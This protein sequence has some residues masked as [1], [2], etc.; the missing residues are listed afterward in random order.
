LQHRRPLSAA[1]TPAKNAPILACTQVVR[2]QIDLRQFCRPQ[3]PYFDIFSSCALSCHRLTTR[4]TR[5]SRTLACSQEMARSL[6]VM[7]TEAKAFFSPARGTE[8]RKNNKRDPSLSLLS[9]PPSLFPRNPLG[10]RPFACLITHNNSWMP[11]HRLEM[12]RT[13]AFIA[14]KPLGYELPRGFVASPVASPLGDGA[15]FFLLALTGVFLAA[16]FVA[17]FGFPGGVL[18][19]L[20]IAAAAENFTAF[21]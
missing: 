8:D 14:T 12:G 16:A 20:A 21:F 4:F 1:Q 19:P 9:C 15:Y 18:R 6:L 7:K 2:R 10:S 13:S 17:F 5:Y 3:S 11:A